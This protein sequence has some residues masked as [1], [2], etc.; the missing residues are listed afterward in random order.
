MDTWDKRECGEAVA[1]E[2]G[3]VF[4]MTFIKMDSLFVRVNER[5]T[6]VAISLDQFEPLCE[7]QAERSLNQG[8]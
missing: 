7:R 3:M 2:G 8:Y 5:S 1:T 4:E 6:T